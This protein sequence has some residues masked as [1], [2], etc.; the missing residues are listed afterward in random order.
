MGNSRGDLWQVYTVR[1]SLHEE[2]SLAMAEFNQSS[3][4]EEVIVSGLSIGGNA[5]QSKAKGVCV[6]K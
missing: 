5:I 6:S 4:A 2:W 3:A 1:L